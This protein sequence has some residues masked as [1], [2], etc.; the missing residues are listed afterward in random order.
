[1]GVVPCAALATVLYPDHS[2]LAVV[3]VLMQCAVLAV[4]GLVGGG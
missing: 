1:M 3:V 4:D 2:S